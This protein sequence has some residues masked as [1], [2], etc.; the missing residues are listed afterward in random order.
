MNS[1]VFG[2]FC[3]VMTGVCWG[4][5]G[6]W[7]QFLFE[8]RGIDS[9]WLV[10]IRILTAGIILLIYMYFKNLVQVFSSCGFSLHIGSRI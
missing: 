3:G 9:K 1:K 2:S 6:V 8:T 4:V 5:S 10:P 7:G